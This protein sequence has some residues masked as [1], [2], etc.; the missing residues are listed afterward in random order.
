MS[1]DCSLQVVESQ[2]RSGDLILANNKHLSNAVQVNEPQ[3][4]IWTRV[5]TLFFCQRL[6]VLDDTAT[7]SLLRDGC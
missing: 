5:G 6:F 7:L 4:L 3:N 2:C 1:A